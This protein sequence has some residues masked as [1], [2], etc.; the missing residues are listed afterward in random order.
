MGRKKPSKRSG[1]QTLAGNGKGHG[2][3]AQGGQQHPKEAAHSYHFHDFRFLN[4]LVQQIP[5]HDQ[6]GGGHAGQG[7][8]GQHTGQAQEK[9][10]HE[11]PGH[12][13]QLGPSPFVK[14]ELK[15]SVQVQRIHKDGAAQD[16]HKIVDVNKGAL[17]HLSQPEAHSGHQSGDQPRHK[18]HW[19][20]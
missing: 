14:Q 4:A 11:Q 17:R 16:P 18:D 15:C 8:A 3:H 9:D 12:G 20:D 2:R 13:A 6:T 5:S 1:I 19:A 7:G 10:Q